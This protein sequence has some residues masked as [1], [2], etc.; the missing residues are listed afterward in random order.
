MDFLSS[1]IAIALPYWFTTDQVTLIHKN[2]CENL[3]FQ[4]DA[5]EKLKTAECN[6]YTVSTEISRVKSGKY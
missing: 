5:E 6:I 4:P 1:L 3:Y 2:Y